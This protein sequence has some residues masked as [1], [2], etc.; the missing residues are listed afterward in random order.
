MRSI[1]FQK[2]EA[3]GND[4][5]FI[6]ADAE[7]LETSTFQART[8]QE[9]CRREGTQGADGIVLYSELSD[10]VISMTIINSDGSLGEM[11]GNALRCLAEILYR[12]DGR[13]EHRVKLSKR[14]VEVT[15]VEPGESSVQMG[16][17]GPEQ[18]RTLFQSLPDLNAIMGGEG[19]LLSFGNPHYV[20]A[21][22]QIPPD[23]E[24]RG[25]GCQGIAD[26]I[27]GTGGINCGF[28][29]RQLDSRACYPLKVYERGA[30][31]TQSC[32]SGACA[33]SAILEHCEKIPAP[34]RF[35]LPGGVLSID[36]RDQNFILTGPSSKQYEGTWN[37]EIH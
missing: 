8:V 26:Q 32:G 7:S 14:L 31:A 23:W 6:D 1:A 2:W 24:A 3:T 12:R 30:G 22:E 18:N 19:Y 13:A 33:A 10:R 34:H 35:S 9:L 25:A 37:L 20:V 4:F 11:C 15:C 29:Q 5:F 36:R 27:L 17:V 28:L 16:P 21:L